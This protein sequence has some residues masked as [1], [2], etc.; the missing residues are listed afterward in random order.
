MPVPIDNRRMSVHYRTFN[1]RRSL[2]SVVVK[3][4]ASVLGKCVGT[5]NV[6]SISDR[7]QLNFEANARFI[8][9]GLHLNTSNVSCVRRRSDHRETT[10]SFVLDAL[11]GGR[12]LLWA[13]IIHF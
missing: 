9:V 2:Q 10:T 4:E 7:E 5:E 1:S 3:P 6:S 8:V 12:G 11:I 13:L